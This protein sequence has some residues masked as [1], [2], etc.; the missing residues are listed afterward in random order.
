MDSELPK[1]KFIKEV[2]MK[3]LRYV[4]YIQIKYCMTCPYL[5]FSDF[6]TIREL[7]TS[8]RKASVPSSRQSQTRHSNF[9]EMLAQVCLG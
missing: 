7:L 8:Y 2:L 9:Q 6:P 1:P 5:S 3:C 4:I